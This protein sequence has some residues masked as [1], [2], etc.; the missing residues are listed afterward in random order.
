VVIRYGQLYGP[1]TFY[2]VSAPPPPRLHVDDTARHTLP[3]LDVPPGVTIVADDR[4][5][6]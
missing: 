4:A 2:P 6:P 3:A 1:G 5:A